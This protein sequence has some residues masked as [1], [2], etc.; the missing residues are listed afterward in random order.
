[1]LINFSNETA[2]WLIK[3]G[4]GRAQLPSLKSLERSPDDGQQLCKAQLE[5][6]TII[7]KVSA[8]LQG[9]DKIFL[10]NNI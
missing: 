1:M 10:L 5:G 9:V 7:Q 3:H 8:R 6:R 2:Y 4:L